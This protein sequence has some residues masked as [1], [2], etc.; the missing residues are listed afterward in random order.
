MDRDECLRLL[1]SVRDGDLSPDDMLKKLTMDLNFA[2][3]S[4]ITQEI[5]EISWS[6]VPRPGVR[7]DRR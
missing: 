4:A 1:N 3:Q 7:G 5:T 2:R 6:G